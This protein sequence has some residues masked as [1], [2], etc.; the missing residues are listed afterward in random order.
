[1]PHVTGTS[2]AHGNWG[3]NKQRIEPILAKQFTGSFFYP[4]LLIG[5]DPRLG[6][7]IT[8]LMLGAMRASVPTFTKR[9]VITK[10]L[11][12][13]MRSDK[14]AYDQAARAFLQCIDQFIIHR[15]AASVAEF[16]SF[17]NS[18]KN[19]L[20][21]LPAFIKKLERSDLDQ[22]R[23]IVNALWPALLDE[24]K[25][26]FFAQSATKDDGRT[27]FVL[28]EMDCSLDEKTLKRMIKVAAQYGN[29]TAFE[30]ACERSLVVGKLLEELQDGFKWDNQEKA[31]KLAKT[32]VA[33]GSTDWLSRLIQSGM[34]LDPT[35]VHEHGE[36]CL[37]ILSDLEPDGLLACL[38]S[39]ESYFDGDTTICTY[40]NSENE[41][42]IN[43]LLARLA[44]NG[45]QITDQMIGRASTEAGKQALRKLQ[46]KGSSE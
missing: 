40:Y 31:W 1:M 22:Y 35:L 8:P 14:V 27:E 33:V 37:P 18:K 15:D 4:N 24:H 36:F 32:A 45:F 2:I 6:P 30:Y 11:L 44:A 46:Y 9:L 19:T 23:T 13:K 34:H 12:N 42:D 17:L 3:P 39:L 21:H 43:E 16:I 28:S 25:L 26:I 29:R 41:T 5:T 7:F 20:V 38:F 10:I